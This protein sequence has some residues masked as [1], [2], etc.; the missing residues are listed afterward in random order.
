M[1]RGSSITRV[2]RVIGRIRP[3]GQTSPTCPTCP[4]TPTCPTA[5]YTLI[6][7]DMSQVPAVV[8][9]QQ[10]R[11]GW[12]IG[13]TAAPS[14]SMDLKVWDNMVFAAN[15]N[16]VGSCGAAGVDGRQQVADLFSTSA[17]GRML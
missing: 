1:I 8:C 7:V 14:Q 11:E 16:Q 15:T 5:G 3:I 17:A 9:A 13:L 4:T 10:P 2:W 12:D 6:C